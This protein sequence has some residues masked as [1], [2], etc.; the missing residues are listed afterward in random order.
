MKR[1]LSFTFAFSACL[2]LS[3]CAD[4]FQGKVAMGTHAEIASLADVVIPQEQ[5]EQLASP[6]QVFVSS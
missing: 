5:I 2:L 6:R 3:S 4:F 1:I